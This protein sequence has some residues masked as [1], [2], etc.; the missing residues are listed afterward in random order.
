V[1]VREADLDK[2]PGNRN[3]EE[4]DTQNILRDSCSSTHSSV[5][6]LPFIRWGQERC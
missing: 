4:G 5:G 1:D 6:G 2:D 3:E